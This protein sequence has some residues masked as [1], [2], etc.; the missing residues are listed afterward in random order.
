MGRYQVSFI[1]KKGI[2]CSWIKRRSSL[3]NTDRI[4][5][6]YQDP[7]VDHRTFTLWGYDRWYQLISFNPGNSNR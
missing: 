1:K 6:L 2:Y 7:H 4:D 5:H 3:F